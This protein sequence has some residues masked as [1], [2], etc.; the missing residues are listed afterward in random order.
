MTAQQTGFLRR[1]LVVTGAHLLALGGLFVAT[2]LPGCAHEPAT[3]TVPVRL[4]VEIP[5]EES[6]GIAA[7]P[8]PPA[9]PA[10]A[11]P[12]PPDPIGVTLH[13][14]TRKAVRRPETP[15][16]AAQTPPKVHVSTTLVRRHLPPP[17][18]PRRSKLTPEEIARLLERGATPGRKSSLSDED[19]RKLLAT[20]THFSNQGPEIGRDQLNLELIRQ[21][22]YKAWDQP[23]QLANSGL[24]TM[25]ELQFLRDGTVTAGRIVQGSGNRVMDASVQQALQAVRRIYGLSPGFLDSRRVLTIAF[26]LTGD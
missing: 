24:V 19:M 7:H 10:V 12:Q 11:R 21:T 20:D 16:P 22:L 26:E 18:T 17:T 25:V 2:L 1:L 13:E 14:D 6:A 9:P 23:A 15:K 4:I 3:L 5:P 8:A